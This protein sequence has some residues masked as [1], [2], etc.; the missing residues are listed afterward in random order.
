MSR[1]KRIMFGVTV[2]AAFC[3]AT[4]TWVGIREHPLPAAIEPGAESSKTEFH[5]PIDA[6]L[7]P[8]EPVHGVEERSEPVLSVSRRMTP[9][10]S[11][12]RMRIV[13]S[14]SAPQPQPKLESATVPASQPPRYEPPAPV[15]RAAQRPARTLQ[16][17]L[18]RVALAYVGADIRAEAYWVDA[19]FDPTLPDEERDDLMEDLNEVGFSNGKLPGPGDLPLIINRI[20]IVEEL[21]PYADDFMYEHLSEAHK[22][23]MNMLYGKMPE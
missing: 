3:V 18:A 7:P 22:D 16:D 17:P 8:T 11:G 4:A 14:A 23:L 21:V 19:I 1:I 20:A 13:E 10:P 6:P 12:N 15:V 2:A 9:V 5:S